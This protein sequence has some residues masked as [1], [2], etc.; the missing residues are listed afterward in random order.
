[1]IARLG[2]RRRRKPRQRNGTADERLPLHVVHREW[3]PAA[4]AC[5]PHHVFRSVICSVLSFVCTERPKCRLQRRCSGSKADALSIWDQ[6]SGSSARGH[7]LEWTFL[8]LR[9]LLRTKPPSSDL[10]CA[11]HGSRCALSSDYYVLFCRLWIGG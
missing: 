1:M 7:R 2:T 3:A 8:A 9:W 11:L 4:Q 6:R 5:H 10:V